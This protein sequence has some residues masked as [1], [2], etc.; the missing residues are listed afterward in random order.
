[1]QVFRFKHGS[2][3]WLALRKKVITATEIAALVGLHQYKSLNALLKK[4]D[5]VPLIDNKYMRGGRIAEPG[6]VV[7]AA[8]AGF[9]IEE[10]APR[11][12]VEMV[13]DDSGLISASLDAVCWD[14][15]LGKIIVECKSTENKDRFFQ[16]VDGNLPAHYLLQL[17][18]QM[19]CMHLNY[20]YY[21]GMLG[22]LPNPTV[23][24]KI[25]FNKRIFE[26]LKENVVLL[27][28]KELTIVNKEHKIEIERLL[29]EGVEKI[30]ETWMIERPKTTFELDL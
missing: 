29:K 13:I 3:E 15:K 10:A 25:T 5:D 18:T 4:E 9:N 27:R 19:G 2:K 22:Q 7:S 6:C 20:G 23:I 28:K 30:S 12:M 14:P 17:Q 26:L 24:Y 21:V 11:G 16:W 8:E 1:M